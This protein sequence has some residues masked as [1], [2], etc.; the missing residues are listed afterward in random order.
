[1]EDLRVKDQKE[2]NNKM[3]LLS[4]TL[5]FFK[6]RKFW[7]LSFIIALIIILF[8]ERSGQEIGQFIHDFIGNLVKYSKF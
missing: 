6:K 4:K 7:L 8:P 1:M 5:T 3:F 2:L